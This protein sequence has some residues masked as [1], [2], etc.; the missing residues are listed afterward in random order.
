MTAATACR[1]CG[2]E[3]LDNAR[4]CHGC[5][6]NL[7]GQAAR[8][9]PMTRVLMVR[10]PECG[11]FEP[12]NEPRPWTGRATKFIVVAFVMTCLVAL[13][14]AMLAPG[15]AVMRTS[16]RGVAVVRSV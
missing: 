15:V 3:P 9:E 11:E 13:L 12:A 2:T 1:T 16:W 14:A 6:Y 4:F 5:G 8:R 7:R 10:C